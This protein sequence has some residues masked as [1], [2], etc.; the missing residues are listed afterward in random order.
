M[1][2]EETLPYGKNDD[3]SYS[4]VVAFFCRWRISQM[5]VKNAFLNGDLHE[6]VYMTPHPSVQH[7][8]GE[9]CR[10]CKSLYGLKKAPRAWFEKFST[11][12]S[13]LGFHQSNHD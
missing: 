1:D 10:L 11:V 6:K 7:R 2:Y 5:D 4:V 13:S 3:Y 8:P 9:I 12:I